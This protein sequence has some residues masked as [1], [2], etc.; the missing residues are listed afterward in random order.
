MSSFQGHQGN[1]SYINNKLGVL[2]T[3]VVY[4][5]IVIYKQVDAYIGTNY[6]NPRRARRDLKCR[7]NL[8]QRM[9]DS[10]PMEM[11]QAVIGYYLGKGLKSTT[12]Q[13][14]LVSIRNYHNVKGM[15]C[16]ALDE[17][18]IQTILRG[19]PQGG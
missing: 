12:I 4:L 9:P 3:P 14:F 18:L 8:E 16:P 1:F 11:V 13:G 17:K 15:K 5:L 7:F 2:P 19:E 10:F 6:V